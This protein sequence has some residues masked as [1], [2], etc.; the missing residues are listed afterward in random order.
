ME[1]RI[2][3]KNGLN[4]SGGQIHLPDDFP[5]MDPERQQVCEWLQG[6]CHSAFVALARIPMYLNAG[7]LECSDCCGYCPGHL[8]P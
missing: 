8:K 4:P 3:T 7:A 5:H 1:Q 6:L 2:G